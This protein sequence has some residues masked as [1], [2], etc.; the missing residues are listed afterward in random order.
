MCRSRLGPPGIQAICP[1]GLRAT[2]PD[3]AVLRLRRR[4]EPS[5]PAGV[6]SRGY[7]HQ[8]RQIGGEAI[9]AFV[10]AR[11]RR[12]FGAHQEERI[13]RDAG[14]QSGQRPGAGRPGPVEGG[15]HQREDLG[16]AAVGAEQE[17]HQRDPGVDREVVGDGG[18]HHHQNPDPEALRAVVEA[19]GGDPGQAIADADRGGGM[20]DRVAGGH[21]GGEGAGAHQ[22][23]QERRQVD[24]GQE[25]GPDGV[26]RVDS[27]EGE[28]P[29]EA[30]QQDRYQEDLEGRVEDDG[31]LQ[32]AVAVDGVALHEE[33]GPHREADARDQH[34]RAESRPGPGLAAGGEPGRGEHRSLVAGGELGKH[35]TTP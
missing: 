17:R 25:V 14:D 1:P 23:D 15:E 8:R 34:R 30:D 5:S 24:L 9:D 3:P 10:Q 11:N 13:D 28:H 6:G 29:A 7:R 12:Q 32:G 21:R 22:A 35:L 31:E 2:A 27:G 26:V 4:L 20:E 16:D 18:D 33:V 19:A